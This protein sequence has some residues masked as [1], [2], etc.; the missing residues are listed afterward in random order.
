MILSFVT[1]VYALLLFMSLFV[2]GSRGAGMP[3][4]I[5]I[6]SVISYFVMGAIYGIYR[7][8]MH[9]LDR[10]AGLPVFFKYA[11]LIIFILTAVFFFMIFE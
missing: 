2:V 4:Y 1:A 7:I 5:F 8:R 9:F 11:Y 3:E 6:S 10:E